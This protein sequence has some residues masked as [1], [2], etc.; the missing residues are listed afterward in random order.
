MQIKAIQYF[1]DR[2]YKI[3]H[4]DGLSEFYPS[5]TTKLNASPKPFLAKWR[6]DIGNREADHQ[7]ND[8]CE[9]GKRIHWACQLF[10]KGGIVIYNPYSIPNFTPEQIDALKQKGEIFTIQDQDEMWQVSKFQKWITIVQPEI[11]AIESMVYNEQYK[12][13]GTLD[14]LLKINEGKY[15]IAGKTPLELPPGRYVADL[16]SGGHYDESSLQVA[17]YAEMVNN[18]PSNAEHKDDVKGTLVIHL[19]SIV[20]TGIPG[21]STYY[22]NQEEIKEDFQQY[23]HVA[24]VWEDQNKNAMPRLLEFPSIITKQE[25]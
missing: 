23:R 10:L 3:T 13:A 18:D 8:A 7:M 19:N 11:I 14:L 1:D 12:E 25:V 5:V 21:L 20:K 9:K 24:Q 22:R 16:K 6:G 2:F 17:A 4:D 15:C